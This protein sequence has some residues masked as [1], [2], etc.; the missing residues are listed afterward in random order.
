VKRPPAV[1]LRHLAVVVPTLDAA[2]RDYGP[3]LGL[4]PCGRETV[5]TEGTRVSFA[6]IGSS[7]IEFLEP[8]GD[9]ALT[10]F[11]A[12]RGAGVHHVA[13]EVP[14]LGA[15]MM[16]ARAAGLRLIDPAPRPGA[17]GTRVAFVHPSTTHGLLV[18]LVE[19]PAGDE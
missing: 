5:P 19:R 8:A 6:P 15:A 14:D 2:D 7:R 9:G 1:R 12:R 16:R 18:E 11:L 13:L 10:R 17:Q 3:R 4:S